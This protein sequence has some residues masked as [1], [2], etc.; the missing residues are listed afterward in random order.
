MLSGTIHF[1]LGKLSPMASDENGVVIGCCEHPST[2]TPSVLLTNSHPDFTNTSD[3]K[4]TWLCP[5]TN[6]WPMYSKV[7]ESTLTE[8]EASFKHLS[9][10]VKRFSQRIRQSPDKDGEI[11]S[12]EIVPSEKK[13][14]DQNGSETDGSTSTSTLDEV[15]EEVK[16]LRK[17]SVTTEE[18]LKR[19]ERSR[20]CKLQV[21][22]DESGSRQI[23][24][25]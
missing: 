4:R 9:L 25:G 6:A 2:N 22:K 10:E 24:S 7:P 15:L 18:K 13:K 17:L 16:E 12:S 1:C 20:E 3:T 5:V 14:N 11:G 19:S 8:W 21:G 23:E